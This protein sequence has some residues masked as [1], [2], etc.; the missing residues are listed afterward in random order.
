VQRHSEQELCD[1]TKHNERV[2]TEVGVAREVGGRCTATV[3]AALD[4]DD[5]WPGVG[6][7]RIVIESNNS[8]KPVSL[9]S[10]KTNKRMLSRLKSTGVQALDRQMELCFYQW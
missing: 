8:S 3:D 2:F 6:T 10:E 5:S 1:D 4:G 9:L 7:I